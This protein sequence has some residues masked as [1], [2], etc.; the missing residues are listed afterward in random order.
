[1]KVEIS[2][3]AKTGFAAGFKHV[4]ICSKVSRFNLGSYENGLVFGASLKRSF[5]ELQVFALPDWLWC[6]SLEVVA[7]SALRTGSW[8]SLEETE[9]GLRV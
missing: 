1:M 4:Y 3:R 7:C 6:Q 9:V 5:E 2:Y 8:M